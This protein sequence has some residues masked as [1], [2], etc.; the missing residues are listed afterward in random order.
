[1][2]EHNHG[3]Y[4]VPAA[5]KLPIIAALGLFLVAYGS[6]H[7]LHG[8][9][10]GHLFFFSGIFVVASVMF[11]WFR[12]VINENL[13]GLYDDQVDRSFRWG[14]VWFIFSEISFFGIF[15]FVLFDTGMSTVLALVELA[16]AYDVT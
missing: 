9:L 6:L 15:F 7:L 4:Y 12:Q 14:M 11:F 8:N 5:S 3:S 13:A 2:A 16:T 1:M 10:I